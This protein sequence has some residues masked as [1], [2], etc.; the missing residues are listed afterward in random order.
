MEKQMNPGRMWKPCVI[1]QH[2]KELC[3]VSSEAHLPGRKGKS[4]LLEHGGSEQDLCG[5][6]DVAYSLQPSCAVHHWKAALKQL[7]LSKLKRS[8]AS[9]SGSLPGPLI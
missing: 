9:L 3:L 4:S 8:P 5:E 7:L 6:A 1:N 2:P